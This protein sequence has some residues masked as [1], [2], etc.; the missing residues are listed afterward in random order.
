MKKLILII[1]SFVV[2]TSCSENDA[3][4]ATSDFKGEIVWNKSFGG[5]QTEMANSIVQTP[6]GG[7][8]VLGY[9]DSNDFDVVKTHALKDVWL[10]KLDANGNLVWT[11]T[12]GGSDDDFGYSIIASSDGNYVI[13]G[14]SGSSDGDVPAN[15]GFHD[16]YVTKI[17]GNGQIIWKKSYGFN[18][19][20]HAHKIIQTKDGGY[21]VVGFADYSGIEGGGGT[22]NNGSGHSMGKNTS[23]QKHGVG[24]YLGI[25]IDSI[26]NFK[27]YRY[28]GGTNNDRVNDVIETN[29]GEL[30][31]VGFSE[32]TNFDVTDNKGTY[33][34]WVVK[35]HHDGDVMWKKSYGGSDI[36]QA[37]GIAASGNNNFVITG[38]SNS[39]DGDVTNPK[40]N[41]DVW[42][43][44]INSDGNLI[45]Q[46]SLGGSEYDSSNAIKKLKNGNF[47]IVGNSRS[48]N[49]KFNNKGENDFWYAVIDTKSNTETLFEKNYGGT[50]FD[51][52]TDFIETPNQEIIIIGESQSNNL[53]VVSNKGNTDLFVL[54]IK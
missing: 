50:N 18:S 27:W 29:L 49:S 17:N 36:D 11:K 52:A 51:I 25:K 21:F 2:L 43:I 41:F 19:H 26:G 45:W 10:N 4:N 44:Q 46:K 3:V 48:S 1:S 14:Y 23:T 34:Y 9:T 16:F 40:G 8:L 7:F 32:S 13:A 39:L 12:I 54:K 6:D 22:G 28:F 24:E 53:D 35:L 20:D 30:M 38:R 42:V 15:L 5:S 33:D 37:F 31:L 47:G